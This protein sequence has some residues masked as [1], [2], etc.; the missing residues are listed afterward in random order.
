MTKVILDTNFILTSLKNRIDFL[1][2]IKEMGF[3]PVVP[4]QVIDE[5]KTI[6]SSKK[7]L[8][9]RDEA[10]LALKII[11]KR[12][13][14]KIDIKEKY[15]DKG[16]ISYSKTHKDVIVATLDR[17]LQKKLKGRIMTIRKASKSFELK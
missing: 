4:K 16:I 13:P 5:L 17:I 8:K 14:S 11:K 1:E 2:G 3:K 15:V 9:F 10:E 12:K 6:T 7:K